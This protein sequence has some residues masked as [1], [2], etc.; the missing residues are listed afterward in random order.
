MC[1]IL[2]ALC[3]LWVFH[4]SWFLCSCLF[5]FF[6]LFVCFVC[7]ILLDFYLFLILIFIIFIFYFY[8]FGGGAVEGFFLLVVVVIFHLP[9]GIRQGCRISTVLYIIVAEALAETFLLFYSISRQPYSFLKWVLIYP[10]FYLLLHIVL[11]CFLFYLFFGDC[12]VYKYN[13]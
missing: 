2:I 10:G 4:C 8:F 5:W 13:F 3:F 9:R 1:F 6:C 12:K 11:V 7:C